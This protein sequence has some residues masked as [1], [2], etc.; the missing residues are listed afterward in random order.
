MESR[1][2]TAPYVMVTDNAAPMENRPNTA[3]YMVQA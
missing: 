2:N 3:L 1:S